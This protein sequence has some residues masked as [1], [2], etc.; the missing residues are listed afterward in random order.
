MDLRTNTYESVTNC[1]DNESGYSLKK[2]KLQ[3]WIYRNHLTQPYFA[4]RLGVEPKEFKAMIKD[5]VPFNR[6][7][8]TKL[9]RFMGARAAFNV[10]YFPTLNQRRKVYRAVFENRKE[11]RN[12]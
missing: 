11:R 1:I 12:E 4:R 6:E 7:Q 5:N 3:Q 8:I 2:R 10:I 9:V